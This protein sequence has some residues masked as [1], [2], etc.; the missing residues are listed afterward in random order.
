MCLALGVRTEHQRTGIFS[1]KGDE[2]D[3]R[4]NPRE[5]L[6]EEHGTTMKMLAAL[7]RCIA[8]VVDLDE[9][10]AKDINSIIDFFEIYV[11]RY[12]HGNEEQVLFPA[13]SRARTA[14]IDFLINS[15]MEDHREARASMEQMKSNAVT[16]HFCP[17]A[18]RHE[19][20]Q[21]VELYVDFVRKHIRKENSELLPL[22][23][24]RLSEPERLRIAGQFHDVEKA[25]LGPSGLEI[26]LASVQRL[27][28]KYTQR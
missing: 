24:E 2:R 12:H 21:R 7:Q 11:D 10:E 19:F 8:K 22:I 9:G 14:G 23:D 6:R 26:F 15:L 25:T 5:T 1:S 17:D 18:G 4:M 20:R 28:R 16:L 3:N 27:S 13:L